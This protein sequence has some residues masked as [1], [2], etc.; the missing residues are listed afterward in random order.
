VTECGFEDGA[1]ECGFEAIIQPQDA[2]SLEDALRY[3]RYLGFPS[4]K[5]KHVHL[6]DTH[7]I[8]A[9]D[10]LRERR[11]P[12]FREFSSAE[13]GALGPT[14]RDGA[15]RDNASVDRPAYHLLAVRVPKIGA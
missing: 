4:V 3:L 1:T 6:D 11:L 2:F 12:D 8:K 7:A 13:P 9:I 10:E 14:C 5:Q 15:S